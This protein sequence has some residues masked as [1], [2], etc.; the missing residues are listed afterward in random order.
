[1]RAPDNF[2]LRR[3]FPERKSPSTRSFR[4]VLTQQ[5][6]STRQGGIGIAMYAAIPNTMPRHMDL[7][8]SLNRIGLLKSVLLLTVLAV[9]SSM[10]LTWFVMAVLGKPMVRVVLV[11]SATLP[12]LLVPAIGYRLLDLFFRFDLMEAKFHYLSTIDSLTETLNRRS[13]FD[14]VETGFAK[15]KHERRPVSMMVMDIDHFRLICSEHGYLTGDR[16]LRVVSRT[17]HSMLRDSDLLARFGSE[18]FVLFLPETPRATCQ[19]F[20]EKLRER[21]ARTTLAHNGLFL[22]F[23]V[24]I[25]TFSSDDQH[26]PDSVDSLIADAEAALQR[27]KAAGRNRV[28]LVPEPA[29]RAASYRVPAHSSDSAA[30][31]VGV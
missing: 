23:T 16:L 21:L 17:C 18:A 15:F 2:P 14:A 25:G 22:Q 10:V 24:C 26:Y 28:E 5:E 19:Q 20:A 13:F 6:N 29:S 27:A 4:G 7:R 12:L 9:I 11:L 1:M 31:G 30:L 3:R 8:A